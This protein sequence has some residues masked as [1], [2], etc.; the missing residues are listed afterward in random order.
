MNSAGEPLPPGELDR[1]L[2]VLRAAIA[3]LE[4]TE[5]AVVTAAATSFSPSSM[6]QH[7]TK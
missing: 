1:Y 2:R 6:Q 3:D 7:D 4:L 5:A